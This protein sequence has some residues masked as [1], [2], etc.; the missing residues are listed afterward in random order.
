M[1]DTWF[2]YILRCA[3]GSYYTGIS[4][5]LKERVERHQTGRGA[6]YTKRRLPV[7]LIYSEQAKNE[8]EARKREKWLKRRDKS[9]KEA[10]IKKWSKASPEGG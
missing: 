3:D 1:E 4:Q 6:E 7:E 10:L 2:V 8:S 9:Q 5:N